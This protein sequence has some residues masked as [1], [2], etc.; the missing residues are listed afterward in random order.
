MSYKPKEIPHGPGGQSQPLPE[1]TVGQL[2]STCV[3]TFEQNIDSFSKIEQIK[4]TLG[5]I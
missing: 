2:I 1:D 5:A 4:C 3:E